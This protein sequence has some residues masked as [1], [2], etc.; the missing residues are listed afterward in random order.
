[1]LTS[2]LVAAFAWV[3]LARG[4]LDEPAGEVTLWP[5]WAVYVEINKTLPR[6]GQRAK[7]ARLELDYW[8]H[9]ELWLKSVLRKSVKTKDGKAAEV[10]LLEAPAAGMPGQ[11]FSMAFLLVD[12]RVVDWASCWTYNRTA[13]QELQLEDVD[14]DGVLDLAFRGKDGFGP[15]RDKRGHTRP[16]DPRIWL[17]AY[18]ITSKGFQSLF[19]A[20]DRTVRVQVAYDTAGQPVK[21]QVT[22]LPESMREY[23]MYEGKISA[24][25]TSEHELAIEPGKWFDF[26]IDKAGSF[27]TY[28]LPDRR[29]VIKPGETVTQTVRFFLDAAEEGAT[30]RLRFVPSGPE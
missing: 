22:G 8:Y 4:L 11:D 16:G 1:M 10:L 19:P 3:W 12:R 2:T 6:D 13:Q 28:R 17:Y 26:E 21:L 24:T 7:S 15:F 29:N 14:G 9:S 25:N 18:A 27:M 30:V 5:H 20:T 23:Q